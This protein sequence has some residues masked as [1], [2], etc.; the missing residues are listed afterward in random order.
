VSRPWVGQN[1]GVGVGVW[2]DWAV[3][4]TLISPMLLAA[5]SDAALYGISA[6]GRGNASAGTAPPK[7]THTHTHTQPLTRRLTLRGLPAPKLCRWYHVAHYAMGGERGV[8][9]KHQVFVP[10]PPPTPPGALGAMCAGGAASALPA[11]L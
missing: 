7:H 2:V 10:P 6:R 3:R 11:L 1:V 9:V 8:A 5:W 4:G